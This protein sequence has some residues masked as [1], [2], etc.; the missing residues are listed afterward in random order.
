VTGKAAARIVWRGITY[1]QAGATVAVDDYVCTDSVGRAIKAGGT[2]AADFVAGRAMT[3]GVVGDLIAIELLPGGGASISSIGAGHKFFVIPMPIV[4]A[5]TV[6]D[7]GYNMP[8]KA[9]V[10]EAFIDVET[11]EATAASKLLDVGFL[12]AGESGDENGLLAGISVAAAGLIGPS[13][14]NA[15]VTRGALLV[16]DEDG[17]GALVPARDYTAGTRSITYTLVGAD[18]AEM[19]ANMVIEFIEVE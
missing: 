10:I 7:T 15:A 3:A 4:A 11:L 2:A 17:S 9:V 8:A 13:L 5:T 19:V 18:F 16:H 14:V 1:V 12:N 6:N